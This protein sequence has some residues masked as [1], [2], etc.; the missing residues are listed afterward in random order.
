MPLL[1]HA[2]AFVVSAGLALANTGGT[3]G[4]L[5]G[6]GDFAGGASW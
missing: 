3:G 6:L 2:L 4:S 1:L 5:G